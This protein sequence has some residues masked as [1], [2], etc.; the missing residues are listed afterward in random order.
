MRGLLRSLAWGLVALGFLSIGADAYWSWKAHAWAFRPI[1]FY[2]DL[3][4]AGW[5]ADLPAMATAH[6]SPGAG[7]VPLGGLQ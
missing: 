2:L 6:V 3:I 7:R 1:G 4:H 5:A